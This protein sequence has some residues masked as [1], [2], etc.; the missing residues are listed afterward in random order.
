MYAVRTELLLPPWRGHEF[1]AWAM[2]LKGAWQKSA[3]FQGAALLNSLGYPAR[4]TILSYWNEREACRTSDKSAVMGKVVR[5]GEDLFTAPRPQEAYEVVLTVG[6]PPIG[7]GG[8]SQ[9]VQW[10]IKAGAAEAFEASRKE[11]F[12]LRQSRTKGNLVSR[13]HRFLGNSSRYL[14]WQVYESREAELAGRQVPAVA[15]FFRSH[16]ATD[17]VSSPTVGEYYTPVAVVPAAS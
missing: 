4:Y 13:L 10:E 12:D 14:V 8:W 7:E 1:E 2:R 16:P 15:E 3:G 9:M 11:L 5:S 6:A 17:Y